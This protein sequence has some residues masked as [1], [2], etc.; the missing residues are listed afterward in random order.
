MGSW[1]VHGC[2]RDSLAEVVAFEGGERA[3]DGEGIDEHVGEVFL[4]GVVKDVL[5]GAG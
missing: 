4:A 2:R 3:V 5:E 1:R